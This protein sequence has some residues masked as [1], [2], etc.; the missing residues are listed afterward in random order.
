MAEART[1]IEPDAPLVRETCVHLAPHSAPQGAAA[2][3]RVPSEASRP[4]ILPRMRCRG[5]FA[6]GILALL[7]VPGFGTASE[8]RVH[9]NLCRCVR[10]R[11]P[12]SP[13][14]SFAFP[15]PPTVALCP[16]EGGHARRNG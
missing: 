6:G 9:G 10:A 12:P 13:R 4:T 5:L 16:P 14:A 7:A 11:L 15:R 1:R 8:D 2:L 3:A